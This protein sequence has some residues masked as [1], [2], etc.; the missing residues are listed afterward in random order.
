MYKFARVMFK[1]FLGRVDTYGVQRR[2]G[3]KIIYY[4]VEGKEATPDLYFQHLRGEEIVGIYPL[5]IDGTTHFACIDVDSPDLEIVAQVRELLPEPNY[6]EC[7]RTGNYHIWLFFSAPLLVTDLI[8]KCQP[9]VTLGRILLTGD[10]CELYPIP[11]PRGKTGLMIALP[12]QADALKDGR[13]AFVDTNGTPYPNQFEFLRDLDLITPT[14]FKQFAAI[15]NL[16]DASDNDIL[17]NTQIYNLYLGKGKTT[18]DCTSSGYD[19]AFVTA[20]ADHKISKDQ[21]TTLLCQRPSVHSTTPTYITTTIEA[22]FAFSTTKKKKPKKK[23]T[24][25][26]QNENAIEV[27]PAEEESWKDIVPLNRETYLK[28]ISKLIVFRDEQK[29]LFDIFFASLISNLKTSGRPVWLFL[30][31]PPGCGKTLPMMTVKN[32]PFTYVV[33]AFRPAALISGWGMQ[34]GQDMSLI[35]KLNNKVLMVKDMS[36]LLS[37][38]KEVV[39]EIL[40]LLRDAYDGSCSK[41][42]GTGVVRSYTS[43]FGFIGATTPEIDANWSMNVRLGERFLRYRIKTPPEQIYAKIE[44]SLA[45]LMLEDDTELKLEEVCMGYLKY[46]MREEGQLPPLSEPTLIGRLAQLGA[47]LRSGVSR[48][49]F[50]NQILVMPEWEEATRFAKQLAKMALALAYIRGK[51]TNDKEEFEDLKTLVR[52]SIDGRIEC[53]CRLLYK[54]KG[55]SASDISQRVHLPDWTVRQLLQDLEILRIVIKT[56]T[57]G[58]T[59]TYDFVPWLR[60]NIDAFK[61]WDDCHGIIYDHESEVTKTQGD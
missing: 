22:G 56:R 48:A 26:T 3:D 20:L 28:Q 18:G 31:G 59:P 30:I 34:S 15:Q 47:I 55:L 35:P 29:R 54:E 6:L 19:F 41:V 5:C 24:S 57:G 16:Q 13:T 53:V 14:H 17:Q 36:S 33:S 2:K 27:D 8:T 21:A 44:S 51:P 43:R 50:G 1:R 61:L 32:S 4:R 58:Y 23:E 46:L 45:N 9:A 60:G 11:Q 25:T 7:S 39:A 42:F 10:H 12:F 49:A 52:D 38:N 37:Q 40:G